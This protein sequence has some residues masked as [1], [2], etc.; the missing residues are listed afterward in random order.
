MLPSKLAHV[1]YM[2]RR[3]DEMLDWYQKVKGFGACNRSKSIE[4]EVTDQYD[5]LLPTTPRDCE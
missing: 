1:V 3:Y 4:A 2:T 5:I